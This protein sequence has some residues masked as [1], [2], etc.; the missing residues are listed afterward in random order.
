MA[1]VLLI[2]WILSQLVIGL[3]FALI[4]KSGNKEII[5]L[6]SVSLAFAILE[7]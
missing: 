5:V 3:L 7:V 4:I 2:G 1:A 6:A